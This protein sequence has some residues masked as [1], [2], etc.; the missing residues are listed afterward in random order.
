MLLICQQR[1]PHLGTASAVEYLQLYWLNTAEG[2]S[3][4]SPPIQYVVVIVFSIVIICNID[5]NNTFWRTPFSENKQTFTLM[6]ETDCSK[7][8]S[9]SVSTS[10]FSKL[11]AS[12][13]SSSDSD[14]SA[15]KLVDDRAFVGESGKFGL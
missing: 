9:S 6:L 2:H 13:S 10:S 12:S 1:R 7:K 15:G 3:K 4:T 11:F 8:L 14:S 5:N